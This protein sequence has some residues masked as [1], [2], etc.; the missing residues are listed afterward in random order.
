MNAFSKLLKSG[1]NLK[2]VAPNASFKNAMVAMLS[3]NRKYSKKRLGV[4]FSGSGTFYNALKDE[5]DVLVVDEA[6]RLKKKGA[7]QY[8]GENQVEDVIKS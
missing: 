2:F 1:K 4:L 5:F 6:H 3:N 8:K 7:Y